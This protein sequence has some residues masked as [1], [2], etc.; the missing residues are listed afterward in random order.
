MFIFQVKPLFINPCFHLLPGVKSLHRRK[1]CPCIIAASTNV[2][3]SVPSANTFYTKIF[4]MLIYWSI[5]RGP[6]INWWIKNR[7][8]KAKSQSLNVR[9][10]LLLCQNNHCWWDLYV[11]TGLY[12]S[13]RTSSFSD[14]FIKY[15]SNNFKFCL[16]L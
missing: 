12:N 10:I 5:S 13:I 8:D 4:E 16:V 9:Q 2:N 7:E 1:S 11:G 14:L 6:I 3:K 15:L